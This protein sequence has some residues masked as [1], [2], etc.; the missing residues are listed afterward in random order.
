MTVRVLRARI[1]HSTRSNLFGSG[2]MARF[3][4]SRNGHVDDQLAARAVINVVFAL[5]VLGGADESD[6]AKRAGALEGTAVWHAG[7]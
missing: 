3:R 1:T 2:A 6:A 7:R 4:L 5:A